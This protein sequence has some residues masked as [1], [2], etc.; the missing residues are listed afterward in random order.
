M[1]KVILGF[2]TGIITALTFTAFAASTELFT[3]Q[4]A[5]F[6]IYV[7]GEKFVS[8]N[9]PVVIEGRTYLALRDTA[10][11]LNIEVGW[12]GDE[13]KVEIGETKK[14]VSELPK[15]TAAQ[16]KVFREFKQSRG[17]EYI[18]EIDGEYYASASVF[19][20]EYSKR[21]G[22]IGYIEIPD[23]EPVVVRI[24]REPTENSTKDILGNIMVKLSSL[25]LEAEIQG[26]NVIIRYK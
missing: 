18:E 21:D 9:P 23:R 24:D 5:T 20:Q 13:R 3:A 6:D 14:T 22:N 19:G 12:N 8:E 15:S 25:G 11:A 4:Q 17:T 16:G 7:K 1:K 10:E 2:V 26:D